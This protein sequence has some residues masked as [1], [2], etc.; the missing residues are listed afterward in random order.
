MQVEGGNASG[1]RPHFGYDFFN[2]ARPEDNSN[3]AVA[4]EEAEG[5]ITR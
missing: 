4:S 2:V 3:A 5:E 1:D